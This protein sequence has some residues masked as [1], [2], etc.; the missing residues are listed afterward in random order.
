VTASYGG[1]ADFL[2]SSGSA[3]APVGTAGTTTS[4]AVSPSPAQVG[5]PVTVTVTVAAVAPAAGTPTG[6]VDV[7]DGANL[8]A[9]AALS[10]GVAT[11]TMSW[12]APGSQQL[13]A[14]YLGSADDAPSQSA[15]VDETV[16]P[17]ATTTT[18]ASSPNPAA[19]GQPVTL[20]ATVATVLGTSPTPTGSVTFMQGSTV[21]GTVSLMAGG[22][23][24]LSTATLVVTSLP[25]GSDALHATYL[26]TS[27]DAPSSSAAITQKVDQAPTTLT[28][29]PASSGTMTATL[30]TP[31]GPVVG[32]TLD[33]SSGGTVLC[34][35]TTGQSGRASCGGLGDEVILLL[36]D[37]YTVRFAGTAQ[38]A[39]ATATGAA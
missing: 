16:D 10:D 8:V 20:T 21:L 23:E 30:T 5:Q 12:T 18:L 14:S 7:Y 17:A 25:V 24:G 27:T 19:Y 29:S 36:N 28:A 26:G 1:D 31:Y 11:I 9:S 38:Y 4:L 32:A 6:T 2:A 13:H 34:T 15:T 39:P 3:S 33:F 22:R 37:G 35:A